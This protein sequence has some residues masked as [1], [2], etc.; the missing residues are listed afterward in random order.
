MPTVF[1]QTHRGYYLCAENRGSDPINATRL[2]P[3]DWETFDL[4]P[5][6]TEAGKFNLVAVNGQFVCAEG[7]GGGPL[8]A[9]RGAAASWEA[10]STELAG[11][12]L[13]DPIGQLVSLRVANGQFVCAEGGGGGVVSANRQSVGGWETFLIE[14]AENRPL[15]LPPQTADLS[16]GHF[17]TSDVSLD[18]ARKVTVNTT[19]TCTNKLF[20]FT[21]GAKLLYV[22]VNGKQLGES[23]TKTWGIDQ[24]PLFQANHRSETW[25]DSAPVGTTDFALLQFWAPKNRIGPI[26]DAIQEVIETLA[27]AAQFLIQFCSKYPEFCQAIYQVFASSGESEPAP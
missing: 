15:V 6:T 27:M 8:I 1:I 2:V 7:G 14:S 18:Q 13:N 21:G 3:H 17:I 22:D 19:L 9:N 24:A 10:F 4:R 11:Q 25:F 20:G 23:V 16:N 5:S 26:L 12:P